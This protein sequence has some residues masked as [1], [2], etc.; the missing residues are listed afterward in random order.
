MHCICK[1]IKNLVFDYLKDVF[2]LIM[3]KK[4]ELVFL[5]ISLY[6]KK[7]MAHSVIQKYHL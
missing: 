4:H 5:L 2:V 7:T 6:I 1:K 3:K